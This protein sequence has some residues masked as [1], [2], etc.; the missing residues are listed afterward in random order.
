MSVRYMLRIMRLG[1]SRWPR[2][3]AF[4]MSRE[5]YEGV[6]WGRYVLIF[7]RWTADPVA[8]ASI[9]RELNAAR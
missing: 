3:I 2:H 8:A 9:E 4:Y 7:R 5:W 1:R 6:Q